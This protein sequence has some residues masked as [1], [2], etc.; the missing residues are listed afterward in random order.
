M[1]MISMGLNLTLN[2]SL[3]ALRRDAFTPDRTAD[4]IARDIVTRDLPVT[5]LR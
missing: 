5:D 2:D 4:R 1:G 3:A